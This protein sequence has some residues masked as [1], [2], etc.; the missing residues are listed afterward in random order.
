[1]ENNWQLFF[2]ASFSSSVCIYLFRS[3]VCM[4]IYKH[5]HHAEN[6]AFGDS[7]VSDDVLEDIE[8]MVQG[9]KKSVPI[10]FTKMDPT[11]LFEVGNINAK[12]PLTVLH[13]ATILCVSAIGSAE[14]FVKRIQEVFLLYHISS[15]K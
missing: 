2:V 13:E 11:Y 15:T 1:M 5:K 10:F 9:I 3:H 14:P 8:S 6:R 4:Q 12:I 7:Q